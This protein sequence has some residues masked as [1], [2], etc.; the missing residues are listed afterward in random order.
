M[1]RVTSTFPPL[2]LWDSSVAVPLEM[3]YTYRRAGGQSI[4]GH[5]PVCLVFDECNGS[6]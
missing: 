6:V 4:D 5:V 2:L 3:K 1:A